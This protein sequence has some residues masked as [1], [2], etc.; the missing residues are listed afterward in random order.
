M[1]TILFFLGDYPVTVLQAALAAGGFMTLLVLSLLIL[2]VRQS[3]ARRREAEEQFERQS[4]ADEQINALMRAQME[5]F[6]R[7][8]GVG[9]VLSNKQSELAKAVSERLDNVTQRVGENLTTGAKATADQLKALEARLAV[10]D[11]AQK[12]IGTL[13]EQVT[14]LTSILSNKQARGAFGQ[15]QMEAIIKDALPSSG[16]SFQAT[17]STRVRPDCLIFL[18]GDHR[19]LVIDAKFPLEA[20][21]M[22]RRAED[23]AGER[24]AAQQLRADMIGHIQAVRQYLIPEETQEVALLFVPSEALHAELHER[25]EDVVQRAHKARVLIVSPSLLM[26]SIHVVKSLMRDAAMRE[27]AHL[28]QKEVGLLIEDVARLADRSNNLKK[29][30]AL[31]EKD[32]REIETSA[33]KIAARGQRIDRMDFDGPTPAA[34][35]MLAQ[36]Q[37]ELLPNPLLIPD[38]AAE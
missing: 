12:N 18:P 16:Y 15:G 25:F 34:Q 31:T 9:D 32:L 24:A 28:I 1:D 23:E 19:G 36:A 13:S 20:F 21:E 7:L 38:E 26:L 14:S 27:Q 30:M 6:G 35:T 5:L 4:R 29:H 33:Q 22:L 11:A 3:G 17:L 2:T 37:S 10:I 8:Q